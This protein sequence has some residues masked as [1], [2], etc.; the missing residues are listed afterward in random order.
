M[1]AARE[2]VIAMGDDDWARVHTTPLPASLPD[3]GPVMALEEALCWL[4][5]DKPSY[6]AEVYQNAAGDFVVTGPNGK[7]VPSA[8]ERATLI[9]QYRTAARNMHAALLGGGLLSYLA[10]ENGQPLAVPRL[11]WNRV[12]PERLSPVY[13][14]ISS[15]TDLGAGCPILLSRQ[16]F[17]E[18][19]DELPSQIDGS[20]R[21]PSLASAEHQCKEWLLK[22]FT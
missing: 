18:W 17:D 2:A 12:H 4:A 15:T 21:G 9:E 8:L 5:Y 22:R 19:R 16:T 11:Y 6:D 13:R 10:P 3:I 14:G 20:A 1:G 7:L